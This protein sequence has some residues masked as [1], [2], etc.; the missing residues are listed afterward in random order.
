MPVALLANGTVREARGFASSTKTSPSDDRELDVEEPD[1]AEGRREATDDS[2]DLGRG[3]GV[4][5]RRRQHAG[6]VAGVDAGLLDVLHDRR[7]VGVVPVAE[8]V[9]VDLDRALEEAVD[10]DALLGPSRRRDRLVVVADLHVPPAEHVGRPHEHRVADRLGDLDRLRRRPA[11]IA[12]DGNGDVELVA[13]RGK[14][15]AVLGE[16]DRVERRAEDPP[17]FCLDLAREL[18]RGLAPELDDDAVGQLAGADLEHL[19][20]AERLEVE[21]VGR[22]VV[23]RDRLGVAVDHHG[24]EA[25]RAVGLCGVDA[26]V[27]ELDPLADPVRA[28]AE[29]DDAAACPRSAWPRRPRPRSSRSSSRRPR[30][31]RRTSRRAGRRA[32]PPSPAAWRARSPRSCRSAARSRRPRYPRA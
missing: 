29:D 19:L 4:E 13:E 9:D 17:A 11:A 28:R 25:E 8:R 2:L 16:V 20:D 32:G 14:A 24:L 23:G 18:E 5:R 22:V 15:L 30:P 10:Q 21:A 3:R 12:Q 7:H 31:R 26:A 1:D 27:V 6:R